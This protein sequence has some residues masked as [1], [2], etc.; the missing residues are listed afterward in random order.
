MVTVMNR[1]L[2]AVARKRCR[3]EGAE[4]CR[5]AN[6][7]RKKRANV[8]C[9]VGGLRVMKRLSKMQPRTYQARVWV[10]SL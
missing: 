4:R 2:D 9:G 1:K 7:G 10:L 6:R 3:N 8:L 5:Q